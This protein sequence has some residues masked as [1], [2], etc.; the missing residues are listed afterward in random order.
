MMQGVLSAVT[1]YNT[2]EFALWH[3]VQLKFLPF[4]YTSV[5]LKLHLLPRMMRLLATHIC[6]RYSCC[7]SACWTD[8]AHS[9]LWLLLW[10]P[11]CALWCVDVAHNGKP[12]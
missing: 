7:V 1:S 3:P 5:L 9:V 10:Q 4:E 8:L 6:G 11:C 2:E 12:Q